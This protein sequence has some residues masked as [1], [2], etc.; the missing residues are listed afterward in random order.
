MWFSDEARARKFM[1]SLSSFDIPGLCVAP[2]SG[3]EALYAWAEGLLKKGVENI[4]FDLSPRV[5]TLAES[6]GEFVDELGARLKGGSHST[7]N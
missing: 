1:E 7:H 2:V 3:L 6:L 4:F 5:Q